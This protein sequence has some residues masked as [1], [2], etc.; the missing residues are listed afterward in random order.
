MSDVFVNGPVETFLD[1]NSQEAEPVSALIQN[2]D[3]QHEERDDAIEALENKVFTVAL[4]QM[5]QSE[6][7]GKI[8]KNLMEL[9]SDQQKIKLGLM[10]VPKKHVQP[11]AHVK[12]HVKKY[13]Q[14]QFR[15]LPPAQPYK[16]RPP[17]K[18]LMLNNPYNVKEQHHILKAV[19]TFHRSSDKVDVDNLFAGHINLEELVAASQEL[20]EQMLLKK[21]I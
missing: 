18:H 16:Y 4:N 1:D 9:L 5:L 8:A 12:S 19:L 10:T 14:S 7:F 15:I 2:Q 13:R 11:F 6:V 20:D 21:H 3:Q 17:L